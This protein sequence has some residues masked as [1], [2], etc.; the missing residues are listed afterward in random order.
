MLQI[1]EGHRHGRRVE[2]ADHGATFD[3]LITTLIR[4]RTPSRWSQ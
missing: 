4:F 1:G 2:D 3:K